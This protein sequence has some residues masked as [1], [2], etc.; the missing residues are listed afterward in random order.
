MTSLLALLLIACPSPQ[1]T[2]VVVDDDLDDDGYSVALGDCDDTDETVHPLADEWCDGID[3]DCDR[4]VDEGSALDAGTFHLD[5]DGDG[6][7]D[8]DSTTEACQVPRGYVED[9]TDCDDDDAAIHPGAVEIVCNNVLE[10][11]TGPDGDRI[12]PDQYPVLQDAISA[13]TPGETICVYEG[14]YD[15]VLIDRSLTIIGM[16]GA[17]RTEIDGDDGPA[18]HVQ[19]VSDVVLTGLSFTDGEA[20]EG[21]GL[22][23]EYSDQVVVEDCVFSENQ[24]DRG[25]AVAVLASQQVE[26]RGSVFTRNTAGEGGGV[27]VV[28]SE[29]VTLS[30]CIFQGNAAEGGGGAIRVQASQSVSVQDTTVQD[31]LAS[32]GGGVWAQASRLDL[33]RVGLWTNV[34]D[35]G[36]GLYLN[37]ATTTLSGCEVAENQALGSQ[38][39]EAAGGG[40]YAFGGSVDLGDTTFRDNVPDDTSC[41]LT[42]GC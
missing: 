5:A 33:A 7:G 18:V 17:G 25:G 16:Q 27:A 11:C 39:E 37:Q 12:V 26:I 13:A 40:L 1:D 10:S 19:A 41:T 4:A 6:F 32:Q 22:L 36:G 9:D 20:H 2:G 21:G 14:N 23:I 24:A 8:P 28:D 42:T 29:D 30:D 3:N 38:V 34:A 31:G 35:H 15:A